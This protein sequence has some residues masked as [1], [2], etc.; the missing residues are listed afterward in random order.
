MTPPSERLARRSERWIRASWVALFLGLLLSIGLWQRAA[1]STE[2]QADQALR[3]AASHHAQQLQQSV[4]HYTDLLARVQAAL[5]ANPQLDRQ[6]FHRLYQSVDLLAHPGLVAIQY[7]KLV[8]ADEREALE[9][10]V[11]Q[12]RSLRPEGY[13]DFE[14]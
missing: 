9:A 11:R 14:V 12:D 13:P 7:A 5:L 10:L 4:T 8:S 6:A 3:Q 2:E 1:Q